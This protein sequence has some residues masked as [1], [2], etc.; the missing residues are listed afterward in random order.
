MHAR[1]QARDEEGLGS[2]EGLRGREYL[3]RPF[4]LGVVSDDHQTLGCP[5]GGGLNAPLH[6]NLDALPVVAGAPW[7]VGVEVV[8]LSD[9]WERIKAVVKLGVEVVQLFAI[10]EP[11]HGL[12][13]S[14]VK[15]KDHDA[16]GAVVYDTALF[17]IRDAYADGI[18]VANEGQALAVRP[19]RDEFALKDHVASLHVDLVELPQWSR[20]VLDDIGDG[21]DGLP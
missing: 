4:Q 13:D 21:V 7:G 19:R 14:F 1:H 2:G 16:G 5:C 3:L 20:A 9:P 12:H 18:A 15:V 8:K 11:L 6:E 10:G 17:Q